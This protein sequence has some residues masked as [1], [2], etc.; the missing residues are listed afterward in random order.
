MQ[1]DI[2]KKKSGSDWTNLAMYHLDIHVY[3][4][5]LTHTNKKK[6]AQ[7]GSKS[8]LTLHINVYTELHKHVE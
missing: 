5:V 6:L 1:C 4:G 7:F 2:N 8:H 3:C